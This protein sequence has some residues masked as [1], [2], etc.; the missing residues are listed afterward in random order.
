MLTYPHRPLFLVGDRYFKDAV[1]NSHDSSPPSSVGMSYAQVEEVNPVI[2]LSRASLA[3]GV[4]MGLVFV[5]LF[6]LG[7][8]S[9]RLPGVKGL[10]W[11]H[12]ETQLFAYTMAVAGMGLGIWLAINL[13]EVSMRFLLS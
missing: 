10:L 4:I 5:I 2:K 1:L 8:I 12:V 11:V 9:R 6:P 3:H 7:A 13:Y